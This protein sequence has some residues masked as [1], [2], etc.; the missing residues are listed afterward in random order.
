MTTRFTSGSRPSAWFTLLIM[1]LMS[2]AV[3]VLPA[4]TADPTMLPP[5]T[6]VIVISIP[7]RGAAASMTLAF[8]SAIRKQWVCDD[9]DGQLLDLPARPDLADHG[10]AARLEDGYHVLRKLKWRKPLL[11]HDQGPDGLDTLVRRDVLQG[12]PPVDRPGPGERR[13]QGGEQGVD[14]SVTGC[15]EPEHGATRL[16]AR[17]QV[18]DV[19]TE[20][21]QVEFD[22]VALVVEEFVAPEDLGQVDLDG[23]GRGEEVPRVLAGQGGAILDP[24]QA[25]RPRPAD[26]LLDV[27]VGH[28]GVIE[29]GSVELAPDQPR[30]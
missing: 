5:R 20:A 26:R 11:S 27:A 15:L 24:E 23:H 22:D 21:L 10:M 8:T 30:G 9:V 14:L 25:R 29:V 3:T 2:R 18:D 19:D 6:F 1:A 4:P 28:V 16:G 13:Q 7:F 17:A 12:L